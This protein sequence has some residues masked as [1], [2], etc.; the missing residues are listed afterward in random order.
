MAMTRFCSPLLLVLE[1]PPLL[2]HAANAR[3]A[4]V[5][6]VTPASIPLRRFTLVSSVL[7]IEQGLRRLTRALAALGNFSPA[8]SLWGTRQ[9]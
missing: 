6:N 4:Q 3:V 9:T 2:P 7:D 5:T 8:Q 1:E